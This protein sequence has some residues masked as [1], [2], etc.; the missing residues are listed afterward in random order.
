M[1]D[2]LHPDTRPCPPRCCVALSSGKYGHEVLPQQ[3]TSAY[4]SMLGEH[5]LH[6]R[7]DKTVHVVAEPYPGDRSRGSADGGYVSAA[8]IEP[9]LEQ[10]GQAD[11]IISVHLRHYS[12]GESRYDEVLR[13]SLTDAQELC[14]A[15][16]YL[17]GLAEV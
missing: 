16:T 12:E 8:T 6:Q 10:F 15:L 5:G 11:P 7:H 1:N 17:V 14:T 3:P 9:H 13:L 4:P 2:E